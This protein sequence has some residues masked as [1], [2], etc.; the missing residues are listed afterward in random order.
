MVIVNISSAKARL[1]Q[2]I[3]AAESGEIV[4]LARAGRPVVKL[5]PYQPPKRGIKLGL[6]K[7]KIAEGLAAGIAKPLTQRQVARMFGSTI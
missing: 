7:G 4:M 5:V 3:E 6:L 1:G 2:L